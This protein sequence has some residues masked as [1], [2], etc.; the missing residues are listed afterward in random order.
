MARLRTV[1]WLLPTLLLGTACT[2]S[3]SLGT[4]SIALLGPGVINDPTNKSLRFDLLKFGLERFCGEMTQRGVALKLSD[5]HPIL[6]RFFAEDC[7]SEVVDEE[8]RK[9][10]LV[11]F[12]GKGYAWTNVTG[13]LGFGVVALVEF[14][15]DFQMDREKT[16]YVYFRPRNVQATT[17]QTHLVESAMAQGALALSGV[18]PNRLGQQIL[19][20]QLDRGF[21]VLRTDERGEMT[22]AMGYVAVDEKPFSPFRVVSEKMTLANDRTEVHSGQQ[23]FVGGFEIAE[24]DRALTITSSIDGAPTVDV[25]LLSAQAGKTMLSTYVTRPGAVALPEAP[26]LEDVIGYGQPW[27]RTVAVPP[28]TYYLLFDDSAVAGRSAPP[29]AQGDD[30]AVKIDY[31]VQLGDAP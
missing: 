21:T 27:Q 18:D 2:K 13:R 28:G 23:D 11:R 15:P 9:S 20:A 3:D 1:L 8:Q 17:F 26:R 6:G 19:S 12:T 25:F 29:Q 7:Q 31:V 5:D 4:S 10:L 16:L 30:R 24:D 22:Y 14:S